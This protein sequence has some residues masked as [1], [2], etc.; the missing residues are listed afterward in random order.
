MTPHPLPRLSSR[1]QSM[2]ASEIRELLKLITR[3]SM[4]SFA[5][6]IPDGT[7][8]NAGAF[9]DAYR[10]VFAGPLSA[11]EALQ[12]S[13][14]EGYLPLRQWIAQRM[15]KAG[16]PATT[17]NILITSGS[18]QALDL[19]GKLLLDAGDA[20]L[21]ASPTY[22]GA[23][24][25]F[26]AYEPEFRTLDVPDTAEGCPPRLMY[27]VPDF[28]NPDGVTMTMANRRAALARADRLGAIIVEDAAYSDLRY[29]GE[30]LPSIAALDADRAGSIEATR[31]LYCGT[32]SKTLS[33]GLRIGWISGPKALIARLTMLKQG[34]DL[35]TATINQVVMHH[36]A[37]ACFDTQ[38]AQ[39]KKLYRQRRDAMLAA[40]DRYAPAAMTWTIPE[41]GMFIWAELPAHIKTRTLLEDAIRA[42]IAFIPGTAFY[43]D[44][45]GTNAMRLSFS[46]CDEAQIEVGIFKLCELIARRLA[47]AKKIAASS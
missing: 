1:A 8:L 17:D 27:L 19:I 31:T 7:L 34:A 16:I 38:L 12:Y 13:A 3:P 35:H 28:A 9:Q 45:S 47:P 18:Q 20:V 2:Q 33:P 15:V 6:G 26:S 46:L 36:V 25:A 24:Q 32:F 4:M 42:D 5:G 41:G 23:L 21:T 10:A 40:L 11:R 30:P 37:A 29:D 43:A 44:G 22:L 14:T 39:A